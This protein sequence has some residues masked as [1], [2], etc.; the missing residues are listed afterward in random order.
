MIRKIAIATAVILAV[1]S[2]PII[3]MVRLD[4][5]IDKLE[6]FRCGFYQFEDHSVMFESRDDMRYNCAARHP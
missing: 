2:M 3:Y 5:R 6:H 4:S 1:L